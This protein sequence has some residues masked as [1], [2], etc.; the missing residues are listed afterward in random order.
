M[1]N[2]IFTIIVKK[3]HSTTKGISVKSFNDDLLRSSF[4]PVSKTFVRPLLD[5]HNIDYDNQII[6]VSV[7]ELISLIQVCSFSNWSH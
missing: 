2:L 5:Y 4:V 7:R 3:K 6:I 1:R